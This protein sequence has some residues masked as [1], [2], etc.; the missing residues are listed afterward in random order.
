MKYGDLK[1]KLEEVFSLNIE[2]YNGRLYDRLKYMYIN[3]PKLI[4]EYC[5]LDSLRLDLGNNCLNSNI[6]Y[7]TVKNE[8]EY[9][10]ESIYHKYKND[11]YLS[12]D[13]E[14]NLEYDYLTYYYNIIEY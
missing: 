14:E 2:G 4:T 13:S 7:S 12:I 3:N 10:V 5:Y 11:D 1:V 6:L 8:I 9:T